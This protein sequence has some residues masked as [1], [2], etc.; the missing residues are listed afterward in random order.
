MFVPYLFEKDGITFK[1][2]AFN[3]FCLCS[4]CREYCFSLFFFSFCLGKTN[5]KNETYHCW[6]CNYPAFKFLWHL[7]KY[8]FSYLFSCAGS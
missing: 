8:L 7:K 2:Y 6:S 1:N 5:T 3:F 4:D